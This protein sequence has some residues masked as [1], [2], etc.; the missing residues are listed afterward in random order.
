MIRA[1]S[2]LAA[3]LFSASAPAAIVF[4]ANL[5]NGQ[6][7]P[8]VV[9]TT[10]TGAPRASSGTAIFMLND[11]RTELSFTATI[12]GIDVDGNQTADINDNLTA[13]HIHAGAAV[14]P[15]TNGAVVWG[16][17]GAPQNDNN[18]NDRSV[19]LTSGGVGGVFTGIWNEFEGNGT[20]LT[21]Q[22][23]NILAGRSYINFHTRQF[24]GGELRGAIVP[25]P[26]PAAYTLLLGGGILLL[27]QV[28]VR[29]RRTARLDLTA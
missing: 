2:L 16:F 27:L 8:P 22:L 26:E 14:T 9:P 11:A 1:A 29:R 25:V 19:T 6:E 18:P 4:T 28:G 12:V 13:A 15:T 3:C 24:G 10:M 23:D 5:T 20:T 21:A 17:F 7:N